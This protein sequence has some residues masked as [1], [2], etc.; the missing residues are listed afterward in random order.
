MEEEK[1][2]F[3]YK[4]EVGV[5]PLAL[6]N[7]VACPAACG[8][9][10]VGVTAF[11]NAKSNVKKLQFGVEK[12]HQLHFGNKKDLCPDL[13]IDNWGIE[14]CDEAKT[15]FENLNDIHLGA[16]K[17]ETVDE[18]KYLG[19]IISTDGSNMKNILSRKAK[20]FGITKQILAILEEVCFGSFQF[21][22]AMI[23]RASL[24]LNSILTNCEAR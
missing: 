24:F 3:I 8:V 9:D 7:D 12:C 21:E 4:G 2:L 11:I 10:S 19:D 13:H 5:P 20:A 18:E 15:G 16:H 17:I 1:H 14:K 6:V 22:V 23:L